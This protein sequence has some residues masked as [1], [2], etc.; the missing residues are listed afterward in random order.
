MTHTERLTLANLIVYGERDEIEDGYVTVEDGRIAAIGSRFDATGA[1]SGEVLSFPKGYKLI[2]GMIDVHIHGVAGADTMD[3]TEEALR[4]MA[5]ALPQEGTTSF[6]ATTITA[7]KPLIERALSNVC[8]YIK[9]ANLPG[10]AE[11]LGVHLEGPFLSPKRAG[12]QPVGAI[13][14][15][16]VELFRRW[17][18]IAGGQ[19]RLVTLAPETPGGLELAAYLKQTGV[20]A[21]IGH[22]DA[23]CEQAVAGFRAGITHAT[24]LFNGMRGM[25]HREPG[26]AGAALLHDGVVTEIIVDG[27]HV[28]PEMVR[29]C[30][31]Q[32]G[33]GGMILITDSMRAKCLQA[34][35]YE[36]GG[37]DVLVHGNQAALSDGTLAGS[38]LK[39]R[40]A[41]ANVIAFTGC[42][43]REAIAMAAVTPARQLRVYDRKGSITVGKDA[44]LVVLNEQNDVILTLCRGEIAYRQTDETG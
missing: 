24:H 44:D 40:D 36:L 9:T 16:D 38:V 43:L 25:H 19:I 41:L 42:S 6:L 37:Q 15:P 13:I 23:T 26:V 30:Y 22:S 12:A 34:G 14:D 32:K 29:L 11:V 7:E 35:I 2:P 31:R 28:H 20:V 10:R 17:Q 3:A 21:S 8:A 18:K 39:M 33:S 27:V 5:E 1:N 4:S